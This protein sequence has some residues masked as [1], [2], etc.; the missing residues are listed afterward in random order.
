MKH[1]LLAAAVAFC[2]PHAL[3]ETHQVGQQNKKFS[4]E[5]LTVKVG[6]SV[7]FTN[8]DPFYHNVFSLSDTKSFD[9][10][11]FGQ[12]GQETVTFDQPGVVEVECAIHPRMQ[13]EIEVKQ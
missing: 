1:Y 5:K 12:G 6:D 4:T 13:M 3:A 2:V 7:Q 10:G 8:Q 9:L 11:S